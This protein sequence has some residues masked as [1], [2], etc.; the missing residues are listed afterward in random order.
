MKEKF[1][2][3][4]TIRETEVLALQDSCI[5]DTPSVEMLFPKSLLVLIIAQKH[6]LLKCWSVDNRS[7]FFCLL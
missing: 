1:F 3:I 6:N 5:T 4:N 2:V 7:S